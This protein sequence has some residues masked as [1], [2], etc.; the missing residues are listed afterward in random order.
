M[1]VL[2]DEMH[3]YLYDTGRIAHYSMWMSEEYRTALGNALG[4]VRQL[5][6]ANGSVTLANGYQPYGE[7]LDSAGNV[8]TSYGFTTNIHPKWLIYSGLFVPLKQKLRISQ[9]D[10]NMI[11]REAT[12]AFA[13]LIYGN[14][15]AFVRRS[16]FSLTN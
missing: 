5:A 3:T 13:Y 10:L 15:R 4:S 1:Y 7:V 8:T 12:N 9:Y 6:D 14:V 11:S 2:A 16:E